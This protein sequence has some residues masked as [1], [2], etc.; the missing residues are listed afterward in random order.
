MVRK[1]LKKI[2]TYIFILIL[3]LSSVFNSFAGNFFAEKY[4]CV[5][6]D[7]GNSGFESIALAF[8]SEDQRSIFKSIYADAMKWAELEVRESNSWEFCIGDFVLVTSYILANFAELIK[9]E[10]FINETMNVIINISEEN[11]F[12]I[13]IYFSG[14]AK[15]EKFAELYNAM[16]GTEE[17]KKDLR[18]EF[19]VDDLYSVAKSLRCLKMDEGQNLLNYLHLIDVAKYASY[20]YWIVLYDKN[21]N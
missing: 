3:C 11:G 1:S 14:W 7:Q 16:F 6:Y 19:F 12:G 21:K 8:S 10:I 9:D 5:D 2:G 13:L 4:G 17:N 20:H 15:K 18:S